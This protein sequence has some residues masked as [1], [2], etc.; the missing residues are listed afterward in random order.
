MNINE[1]LIAKELQWQLT[2]PFF[3][4]IDANTSMWNQNMVPQHQLRGPTIFFMNI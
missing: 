4:L 1:L 3:F 2:A